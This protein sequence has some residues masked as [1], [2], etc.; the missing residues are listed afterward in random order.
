MARPVVG[1]VAEE[2]Y[3]YLGPL[4]VGDEDLDWP[5][6][7]FCD[8][9][10]GALFEQIHGYAADTDDEAGWVIVLD[11]ENAPAEVLPWLAQ[12]VGVDLEPSLTVAEQR[13]KIALP[14]GFRRGS[15]PALRAAIERTL[16]GARTIL[17]DERYTGSAYQLRVRTMASQTPDPNAT[18]AAILT[19]KPVGVVLTYAA[20]T[21]GDWDDLVSNYAT[22]DDVVG[23]FDTWDEVVASPP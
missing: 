12:F 2:L 1:E 23:A 11:P 18:E 5:L 17:I 3:T 9:I 6:L 8:A 15:L 7:R 16:S 4:T 19:Q 10:T 13:L 22:W 20:I 14:E 21:A